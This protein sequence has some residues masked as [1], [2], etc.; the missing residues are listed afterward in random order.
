ME[1]NNINIFNKNFVCENENS[2]NDIYLK[3]NDIFLFNNEV[4]FKK[5]KYLHPLFLNYNYCLFCYNKRK[6]KYFMKN[7]INHHNNEISLFDY[8]R[9]KNIKLKKVGDKTGKIS[10]RFIYSF[11]KDK[12]NKCNINFDSN[13]SS[14]TELYIDFDKNNEKINTEKK[15]I[16]KYSSISNK[17]DNK[18]SVNS[19]SLSSPQNL[20]FDSNL[21]INEEKEEN[22]KDDYNEKIQ[23]L[24]SHIINEDKLKSKISNVKV[25]LNKSSDFLL[26]NQNTNTKSNNNYFSLFAN[27]ALRPNKKNKGSA[28]KKSK[29]RISLTSPKK[30]QKIKND[31][32]SICLGEINEK[33]TLVCG[34]FFCRECI[35]ERIK[36]ILNCISD[37]DKIK[38]P[39]CNEPIEDN[40][41]K[42]LLNEKEFEFYEKIKM[43]IEGLKNKNLIPCPFPD[44]EGFS[45]KSIQYYNSIYVCQNN[46]YFCRK[47]MEPE[48]PK[49]LFPKKKHICKNKYP[50]T[51]KYFRI[52]KKQNL[53]KKCP[54][55]DCWVQKEQNSCNNVICSNIWCNLEFC[56]I[57]KSPYDEYHYKN[58]LSMCFGLSSINSINYFT[59]HKRM[60]LIRCIVIFLI[61]IFVIFPFC[62]MLFSFVI[63]LVYVFGFLIEQSGLR[64]VKL[65]SEF[66]HK[67]FYRIILLFYLMISIA[68][69]PLGHLGFMLIIIITPFICLFNKLKNS[70]DF[71]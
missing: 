24:K 59:K 54:N 21:K 49:F 5:E 27:L 57:C 18:K 14:D 47:C 52:K 31:R 64:N 20:E 53:I 68:L 36:T 37:F 13:K 48:D 39:L 50:E 55:C 61:F 65:K 42:R 7:I 1:K 11:D 6:T 26:S 51:M 19:S 23:K 58:P 43:R 28:I 15:S 38:C 8:L 41:L 30:V 56:W 40:S 71:D 67:I 70:D 2:I 9:Q 32:C 62:V 66:T 44:C 63:I 17:Y 69:I 16:E 12:N 10:R 29:R 34:D 3:K 45:D 33:Y 46:H 25:E 60:R 4:I 35:Y 22:N